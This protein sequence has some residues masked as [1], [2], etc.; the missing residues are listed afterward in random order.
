M[1]SRTFDTLIIGGGAIGCAIAYELS[2]EGQ[3]VA[4]LE[5]R[6]VAAGASGVSAAMLEAQLDAH[7]GEPFLS[8]A[9]ASRDLFPGLWQELKELTG[10][11]FQ[12]ERC[13]I[14][15]LAGTA[16]EHRE[17]L[18]RQD[19]QVKA[20]LPVEWLEPEDIEN[21]LPQLEG[22]FSGALFHAGDGQINASRFT[23][24][25]AE[26]ARRKG[27]VIFEDSPV[28]GFEKQGEK[29]AGAVTP[30]GIF[31]AG[32]FVL[33]GGTWSPLLGKLLGFDLPVEPVRGQLVIF[34]VPRSVLPYPVFKDSRYVVPKADGF[35]LA[36]TTTERAGLDERTTPEGVN[37]IVEDCARLLPLLKSKPMRGATAGLRPQTP[38][39]LPLLG[40]A[41]HLKNL[42]IATGHYRNGILL[43]PITAKIIS[44]VILDRP[45]PLPL[46]PFFPNRFQIVPS[47]SY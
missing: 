19:L 22:P 4:V 39:E 35:L 1:S 28:T 44:S 26:A 6:T 25:L 27:A 33:A 30:A 20:G 17:L 8:L 16:P 15:Q 3:K 9:L 11:D 24:A 38:D 46:P 13:G 23:G 47:T 29:I 10:I 18:R 40:P 14:L 36:G 41:P 2:K 32:Q 43:A 5:K 45:S 31:R 21:S 42:V 37:G 34:E 7:R 12:Y